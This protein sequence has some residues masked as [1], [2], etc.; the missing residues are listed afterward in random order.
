MKDV[1]NKQDAQLLGASPSAVFHR[2]VSGGNMAGFSASIGYPG[3]T[4]APTSEP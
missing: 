2:P 4:P 3:Y 1:S